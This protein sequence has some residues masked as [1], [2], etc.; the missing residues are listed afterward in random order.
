MTPRD[1]R[2]PLTCAFGTPWLDHFDPPIGTGN[3]CPACERFHGTPTQARV[4]PEKKK[5]SADV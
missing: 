2:K 3:G 5:E 4:T 1:Q